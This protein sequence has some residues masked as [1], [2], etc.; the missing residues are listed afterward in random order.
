MRA[1]LTGAVSFPA[2]LNDRAASAVAA[3]SRA[4]WSKLWQFDPA[5]AVVI[6]TRCLGIVVGHKGQ[7]RYPRMR[8]VPDRRRVRAL[9]DDRGRGVI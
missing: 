6:G 2:T 9:R 4:L 1:S 8:R 7:E 3:R 5:V